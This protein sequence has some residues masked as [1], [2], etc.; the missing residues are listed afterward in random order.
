MRCTDGDFFTQTETVEMSSRIVD[1]DR[2]LAVA[3][4]S[5]MIS[6]WWFVLS[7]G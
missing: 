6:G 4:T 3:G 1:D 7:C 5:Y 2:T